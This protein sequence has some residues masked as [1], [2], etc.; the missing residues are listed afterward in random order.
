MVYLSYQLIATR[1][2]T[3]SR[4]GS[5]TAWVVSIVPRVRTPCVVTGRT[6]VCHGP[7]YALVAAIDII[8]YAQKTRTLEIFE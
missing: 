7:S 2:P 6:V 5:R 8:S 1:V 4:T 3:G